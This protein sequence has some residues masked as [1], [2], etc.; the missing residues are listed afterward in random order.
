MTYYDHVFHHISYRRFQILLVLHLQAAEL[1]ISFGATET[2]FGVT[3][4]Q[5]QHFVAPG[6]N[7]H[8]SFQVSIQVVD[9]V[10]I[11]S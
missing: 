9:S 6:Q 10:Q 8:T 1:N 11:N 5:V 7:L 4:G 2:R 3:E